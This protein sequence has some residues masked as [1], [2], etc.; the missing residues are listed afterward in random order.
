[1][2]C[3][4]VPLPPCFS[5]SLSRSLSPSLSSSPSPY[6]TLSRALSLSPS[7]S[8][9]RSHSLP[10]PPSSLLCFLSRSLAWEPEAVEGLAKREFRVL[11]KDFA[12]YLLQGLGFRV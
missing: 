3:F 1:M 6:L 8:L 4:P 9:A 11:R 2:P 12:L 7:L 10:T 5:P